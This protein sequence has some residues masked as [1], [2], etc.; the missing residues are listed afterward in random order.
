MRRR[1]RS[2]VAERF[3]GDR[4]RMRGG[5]KRWTT[6]AKGPSCAP[7]ANPTAMNPPF[8]T[9]G[10]REQE[11]TWSAG[12]AQRHWKRCSAWCSPRLRVIAVCGRP[13][14]HVC[15]RSWHGS[16]VRS[17]RTGCIQFPQSG[18]RPFER[19]RP[20]FVQGERRLRRS[21][22]ARSF[23]TAGV[24]CLMHTRRHRPQDHLLTYYNGDLDGRVEDIRLQWSPGE[25]EERVSIVMETV[26][27]DT[28]RGIRTGTVV[29]PSGVR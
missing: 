20:R 10:R 7:V 13:A 27:S 12:G 4:D 26:L 17:D 16:D 28:S 19:R 8:F 23:A 2:A 6:H 24:A 21:T 14:R 9:A 11:R 3:V 29:Y 18:P 15:S 25:L 5:E 22:R 1:D